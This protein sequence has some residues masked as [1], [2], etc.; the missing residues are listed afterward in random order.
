MVPAIDAA[1]IQCMSDGTGCRCSVNSV[2]VIQVVDAVL[3]QCM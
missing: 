1:L 3:I 2:Y